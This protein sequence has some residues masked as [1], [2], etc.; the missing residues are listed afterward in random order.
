VPQ[1]TASAPEARPESGGDAFGGMSQEERRLF[2]FWATILAVLGTASMIGLAFSLYLVDRAPLLLIAL[3]PI[4]R[5]LYL[6]APNVDP[7]AFLWVSVVRRAA[8][9]VAS[10]HLGRN[11]G[12]AGLPWLEARAARFARFV[13]WL[14]LLFNR[15]RYPA[16]LLMTGPTISA[17]AGISGMNTWTFCG[18]AIPGLVARMIV[19]LVLAEWFREPIEWLLE[20]IAEYRLPGTIIL[21]MG[22]AIHQWRRRAGRRN[23]A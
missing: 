23:T 22:I 19:V 16:V 10:F 13:R 7:I 2:R 21:I 14:E 18:L 12:P 6:V 1:D 8:F 5:H 9:Y 11:L 15:Y 17:L 4:G 3:S 20:L